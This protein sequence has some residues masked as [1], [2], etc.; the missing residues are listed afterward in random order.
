MTRSYKQSKNG[1]NSKQRSQIKPA[2]EQVQALANI[3]HLALYAFA[4]YKAISLHTVSY[5]HLTLPT[6]YSV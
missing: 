5:T 4:V 3:S 6:I 1:Q 2:I